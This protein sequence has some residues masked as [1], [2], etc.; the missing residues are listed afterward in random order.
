MSARNDSK[1]SV[2]LL[3]RLASRPADQAAWVEFVDRYGRRVLHWARA[4]G[5]QEAD[6]QEVSQQVLTK[7]FVQLP[8]FDYDPSRSFRGWLKTVVQSAACDA[9]A[10]VP[11]DAGTGGTDVHQAIDAVEARG[12]LARRIEEEYDV[13]LLEQATRIVRQR[14]ELRTWRAYELT[15]CE[16]RPPSEVAGTLG[17]KVG[18]VYQA[19]SSILQQ[20]RNQIAELETNGSA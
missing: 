5:L 14:V 11:K 4:W 10:A 12:D 17:M 13:E 3:G 9:L 20:L 19:K 18:T 2:T 6:V 1:T 16:R 8:K 15:A 7:V